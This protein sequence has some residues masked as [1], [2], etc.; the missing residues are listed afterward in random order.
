M[1]PGVALSRRR[2]PSDPFAV[3]HTEP[4]RQAR[5]G[6]LPVPHCGNATEQLRPPCPRAPRRRSTMS[7]LLVRPA[8]L[9]VVNR[10]SKD[11]CRRRPY[12]GSCQR[13]RSEMPQC[14]WNAERGRATCRLIEVRGQRC[15][16]RYLAPAT[17]TASS[18]P[19]RQGGTA[20]WQ[21]PFSLWG[22]RRHAGRARRHPS[23]ATAATKTSGPV[24]GVLQYQGYCPFGDADDCGEPTGRSVL[25]RLST[26]H[27]WF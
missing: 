6:Q 12:G 26:R 14:R 19:D 1:A 4:R 20:P 25:L 7:S 10:H 2:K 3:A 24:A 21:G 8:W 16:R 9:A 22:T 11:P 5:C 15:L 27:V 23:H 13:Q 18:R 17:G